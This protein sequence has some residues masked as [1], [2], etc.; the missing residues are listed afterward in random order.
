MVR[1]ELSKCKDKITED[2][3]KFHKC[4]INLEISNENIYWK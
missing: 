3:D 4:K 2:R 1:Q